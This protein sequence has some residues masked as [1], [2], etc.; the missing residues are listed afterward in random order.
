MEEKRALRLCQ[1]YGN[2][3]EKSPLAAKQ[4]LLQQL[5]ALA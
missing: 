5:S 1:C 3:D 2:F 4:S